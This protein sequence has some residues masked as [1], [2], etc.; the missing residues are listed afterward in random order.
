MKTP[1]STQ[2]TATPTLALWLLCGSYF[3]MGTSTLAIV[4][5][6]PAIA[7]GLQVSPDAVAWLVS[8][9]AITFA[10]AAPSLQMLLGQLRRRQLLLSGLSLA[11][12]GTALSAL[13]PDYATLFG[14]RVLTAL[15]CAAIGPVASALGSSL[16]PTQQQGKALAT[17]FLGMT[18]SSVLSVPASAWLSEHIGWR[19][20]LGL[21]AGL[22]AG[23]ALAVLFGV[24]IGKPGA[25]LSLHDLLGVLRRPAL[26]GAVAVML[27]QMSGLFA[28]Y[29][30][31]VPLLRER[32]GMPQSLVSAALLTFG[33]A[34]VLGNLVARWTSTRWSAERALAVSLGVLAMLFA[35]MGVAP[36][37]AAVAFVLMAVWA[38]AN[39]V[40][41]P[42]QQRRLVE[43]APEA[44]G[45]VLALNASALYV[46][47]SGG[48][49]VAGHV[50][51]SRGVAALPWASVAL[52]AGA[53]AALWWSRRRS[54]K[55]GH[56]LGQT[57]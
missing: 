20:L 32:F 39:D 42:S 47:M 54:G 40:F 27:L 28:T 17:V 18:L 51:A 31:V 30:M 25:R 21:V 9:F 24:P 6:L 5:G 46:G 56:P 12:I 2:E 52:V 50:F 8:V 23:I 48:S 15:G 1:A 3:A 36:P 22:D 44:R 49:F 19:A 4:G 45:L 14:A 26:P 57:A 7:G 38:V 10:I 34:G 37:N 33:L 29:T 43:L 35:A 53:M 11:T 41:M 55:A 13:A 16:V